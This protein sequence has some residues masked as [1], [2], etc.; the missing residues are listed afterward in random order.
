M[1]FKEVAESDVPTMAWVGPTLKV[2][3]IIASRDRLPT[4]DFG[5]L[6]ENL[7]GRFIWRLLQ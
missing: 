5:Q 2:K 6:F 3:L 7:K 1:P 4:G